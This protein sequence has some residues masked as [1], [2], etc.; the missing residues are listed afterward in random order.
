MNFVWFSNNIRFE[1]KAAL[2][3][4]RDFVQPFLDVKNFLAWGRIVLAEQ[5]P[6]HPRA[7][8]KQKL[9]MN[10]PDLPDVIIKRSVHSFKVYRD[11]AMDMDYFVFSHGPC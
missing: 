5:L 2:L 6:S 1:S 9:S 11:V 8:R 10:H 7:F 3:K 4:L